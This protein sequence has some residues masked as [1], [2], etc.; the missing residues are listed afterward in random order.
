MKS[1]IIRYTI[2]ATID[3]PTD[4]PEG[5]TELLD[6][7]REDGEANIETVELI[8]DKEKK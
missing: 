5:I 3:I 8:E 7:I 4:Y 1:Q 6:R 2:K